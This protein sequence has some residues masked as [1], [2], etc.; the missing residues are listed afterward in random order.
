MGYSKNKA[1]YFMTFV[2]LPSI[3]YLYGYKVF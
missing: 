3:Y 2:G 1:K